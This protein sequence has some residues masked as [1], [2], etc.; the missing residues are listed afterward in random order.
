M[1]YYVNSK[2]G[3]EK[4]LVENG[5]SIPKPSVIPF[6]DDTVVVL[7]D[8]GPFT[9]AGIAFSQ[10]EYE[11]LTQPTD[12]R[13]KSYWLVNKQKLV[14]ARFIRMEVFEI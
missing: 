10:K 12:T 1:G 11:A 4:W 14:D 2:D 13:T 6:G 5:K 3:K 9:A 8:N 7:V